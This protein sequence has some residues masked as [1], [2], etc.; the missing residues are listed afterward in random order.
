MV[1]VAHGN[2]GGGSIR[3]PASCCGVVGLKPARGRVSLGPDIGHA[4]LVADG[5]MTRTVAETAEILDVLAGYEVGD[6]TWAPAPDGRYAELAGHDPGHLLV[7][8]A[9]EPPLADVSLH[10]ACEAAARDAAVALESLG[11]EVQEI[12]PP[13]SRPELLDDFTNAF[14]PLVSLTTWFGGQLTG[15]EPSSELLEPLTWEMWKRS[16]SDNTLVHLTA[17]AKLEGLARAIVSF[18]HPYDIV[19][20]PTL[21]SPPVKIGQING[22]GP[23]PWTHY[24]RSAQFTPYTAICNVT[25][26][27]AISLPLYEGEGLPIGVH[28]IGRPAREDTVLQVA[29]QLEAVLPWA[30]RV[31]AG[32]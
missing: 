15:R 21:A 26:Q 25:G 6:A 28:L 9:L 3:I 13:W 14:A 4:F 1:P 19:I 23:D 31:P 10:P 8:L 32:F 18:L 17:Q 20:T 27:P 7:G 16:T 12:T 2:D 5:V 29:T 30:D 24:E 11:H 22:L